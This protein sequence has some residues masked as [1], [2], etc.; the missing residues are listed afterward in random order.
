MNIDDF[1]NSLFNKDTVILLTKCKDIDLDY[2]NFIK[3]AEKF[4]SEI[5][6]NDSQQKRNG[7]IKM[8]G[9]NINYKE[10]FDKDIIINDNLII[11]IIHKVYEKFFKDDIFD[12]TILKKIGLYDTYD[13]IKK[14]KII[15]KLDKYN[16]YGCPLST[17]C[18]IAFITTKE[19]IDL[20][21]IYKLKSKNDLD[22]EIIF[23]FG[24]I[25]NDLKYFPSL[26]DKDFD[27]NLISLDRNKNITYALY[28][29]VADTQNIIFDTYEHHIKFQKFNKFV[30]KMIEVDVFDKVRGITSFVLKH[31]ENIIGLEQ[32]KKEKDIKKK[33]YVSD[34]NTQ[35]NYC[36]S[37]L[38]RLKVDICD[39]STLKSIVMKLCQIILLND[40]IYAY[41]KE[42][43][44]LNMVKYI[45]SPNELW[46]LLTRDKHHILSNDIDKQNT[47]DNLVKIYHDIFI[48]ITSASRWINIDMDFINNPCAL[49]PDEL[50]NEFI[51]SPNHMTDK[52]VHLSTEIDL[53]NNV[54]KY[55]I[56]NTYGK[57]FT[58]YLLERYISWIPQRSLEWKE[59]YMKFNNFNN[60]DEQTESKINHDKFGLF[61]GA[62]G[63]LFILNNFNFELIFGNNIKKIMVGFLHDSNDFPNDL[64]CNVSAPDL[65]IIKDDIIIPVEI[66]CLPI[67]PTSDITVKAFYREFKMAKK[68][69]KYY[70]Q[71]ID[72]VYGNVNQGL[73]IFMFFDNNKITT[74]YL[75]CDI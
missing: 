50:F 40:D 63:E 23:D 70:K 67:K 8:I 1:I 49:L 72:K 65:L 31:I 29:S 58:P 56:L 36:I 11:V 57:E 26:K 21:Q 53:L 66:K 52:F 16:I 6:L 28:G 44:I 73:M 41:T 2:I 62:I 4:K 71:I 48:T 19:N 7:Y 17:D 22:Y 59:I 75:I 13:I 3:I 9:K 27:I 24:N 12:K 51:K 60:S 68:Q 47:F 54:D 74:Q 39:K 33:I 69:L 18:D 45:N 20:Y 35:F 64:S 30:N 38:N 61:R 15:I 34:S 55:F 25:L 32:N 14:K 43:I 46:N 42:N 10:S 5:L 37:I